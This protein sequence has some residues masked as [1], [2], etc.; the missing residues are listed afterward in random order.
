MTLGRQHVNIDTASAGST[1]TA[2]GTLNLGIH[3][4]SG[5]VR[6][7]H[8]G[9]L[10]DTSFYDGMKS[11]FLD[12]AKAL[13]RYGVV[14][15][16]LDTSGS[17][18]NVDTGRVHGGP[19]S[20]ILSKFQTPV[21]VELQAAGVRIVRQCWT[22]SADAI[23]AEEAPLERMCSRSGVVYSIHPPSNASAALE[24]CLRPAK[25]LLAGFDVVL[26][27]TSDR[28]PKQCEPFMTQLAWLAKKSIVRLVDLVRIPLSPPWH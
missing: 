3:D 1:V 25:D 24:A 4:S 5:P 17:F 18:P 23:P 12:Y 13:Q 20:E 14:S 6:P 11:F 19:N 27:A 7:L 26:T 9:F 10:V 21:T 22:C 16:W 2:S 8:V 28:S 15:T